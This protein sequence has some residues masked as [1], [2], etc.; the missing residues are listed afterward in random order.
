MCRVR[1]PR[2]KSTVANYF[3]HAHS[4]YG[5]LIIKTDGWMLE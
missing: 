3:A 2:S 1:G 4:L 5:Q